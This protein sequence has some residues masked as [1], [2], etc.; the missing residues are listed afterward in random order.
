MVSRTVADLRRDLEG[1]SVTYPTYPPMRER[2]TR[3]GPIADE[4]EGY[5][6]QYTSAHHRSPQGNPPGARALLPGDAPTMLRRE[7][8]RR[9]GL[10]REVGVFDPGAAVPHRAVISVAAC[11]P[12]GGT[13]VV[14][15]NVD[16]DLALGVH[17][18]GASSLT[19]SLFPAMFVEMLNLQDR[20]QFILPHQLETGRHAAAPC[21]STSRSI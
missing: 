12:M 17:S 1:G 7:N 6:L 10:T 11:S 2:F 15:E 9:S 8:Y 19:A 18:D 20:A 4:T 16:P 5:L 3:S 13:A 14:M 21:P